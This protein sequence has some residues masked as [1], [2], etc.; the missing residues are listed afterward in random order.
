M[1]RST[2]AR[3]AGIAFL[4]YIAVGVTGMTL[5]TRSTVGETIPAK[6]ASIAQHALQI[7][8]TIVCGLLEAVCALLLAV[9]LYSLTREEDPDLALLAMIFRVGEGLIGVVASR[10][11]LGLLWLATPRGTST[12][13][14]ATIEG[15]GAYFLLAPA[16]NM[17]AIFFAFGSALFSWLFLR[18]R[19]IPIPLAWLGVAA[20]VLLVIVLPLQLA[21]F[22]RGPIVSFAW[23]PMAAYEVP[24][25]LWLIIK[26]AEVR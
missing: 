10:S 16:G 20:S 21:G 23:I 18:G 24:L 8:L 4:S 9:T 7:R 25:G 5:T 22:L 14:S 6:I 17:G 2:N 11:S 15:L 12:L 1:T 19:I 3:I 26:G 13:P